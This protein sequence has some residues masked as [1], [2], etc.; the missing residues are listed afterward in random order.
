MNEL[1]QSLLDLMNRIEREQS[2][3]LAAQDAKI[4]A[5]EQEIQGCR[6]LQSE[7]ERVLTELEKLLVR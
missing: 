5:L 6:D 4:V 1:Q 2:R 7:L 3:R